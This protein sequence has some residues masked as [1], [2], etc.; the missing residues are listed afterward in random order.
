MVSVLPF[1]FI[2]LSSARL[3]W[4][5]SAVI[6]QLVSSRFR[7]IG[8]ESLHRNFG[9]NGKVGSLLQAV[10]GCFPDEYHALV[11]SLSGRLLSSGSIHRLRGSRGAQLSA[12]QVQGPRGPRG[13]ETA[14]EGPAGRGPRWPGGLK[15]PGAI[16]EKS[17]GPQK[18]WK[19][20]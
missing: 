3:G 2:S 1:L 7:I 11:T 6:P 9:F 5:W 12:A 20:S 16:R 18:S 10:V 13:P 4:G 14:A 15:C 19:D 8:T 17:V